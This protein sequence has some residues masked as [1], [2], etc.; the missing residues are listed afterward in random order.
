MTVSLPDDAELDRV[1]DRLRHAL[2]AMAPHDQAGAD[3]ER[4]LAKLGARF[5]RR[6]Y[7]SEGGWG[8]TWD[9]GDG[10]PEDFDLM[11]VDAGIHRLIREYCYE[12][13]PGIAD[14]VDRLLAGGDA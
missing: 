7:E 10:G 1:M 3:A 9:C 8:F 5:M 12:L 2:L 11:A 4:A 6:W 14:A 13:T